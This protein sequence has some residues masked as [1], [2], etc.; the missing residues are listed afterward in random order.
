MKYVYRDGKLV[1]W[2]KAGPRGGGGGPLVV[3]DIQP[4]ATQD[5]TYIASR[6]HLRDY[7]RAMGVRQVGNDWSGPERPPFWDR[8]LERRRK[9]R[10]T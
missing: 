5:G 10:D 4:F 9:A 7:E 8:F 2:N 3:P 1:P 6:K